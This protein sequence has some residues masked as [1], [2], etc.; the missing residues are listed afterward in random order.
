[1][2]H[3]LFGRPINDASRARQLPLFPAR[4]WFGH[5][6]RDAV[7]GRDQALHGCAA[8]NLGFE[9][10]RRDL[11]TGATDEARAWRANVACGNVLDD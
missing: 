10:G 2:A 1:M 8:Y 4:Q 9:S 3:D 6:Y 7:E 5:G 11:A